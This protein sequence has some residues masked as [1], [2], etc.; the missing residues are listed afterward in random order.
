MS[1]P[2]NPT[3]CWV[4]V[5]YAEL[6]VVPQYWNIDFRFYPTPEQYESVRG[7]EGYWLCQIDPEC[8]QNIKFIEKQSDQDWA[9]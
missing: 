7:N 5:N 6:T 1:L 8:P 3:S 9:G 4:T 2:P